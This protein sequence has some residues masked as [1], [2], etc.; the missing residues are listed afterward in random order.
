MN[1][2]DGPLALTLTLHVDNASHYYSTKSGHKV[3]F[4][5]NF[6]MFLSGAGALL[7]PLLAPTSALADDSPF[8]SVYLTEVLPEGGV[9]FE[10]WATWKWHKP[11]ER[12]YRFQGRTEIEYGVTN[13]FQIAGYLN[14]SRTKIV[15]RGPGAPDGPEDETH[16]DDVSAEF[17]YQVMDPYTRPFG[18]A[19]YFEPSIGD[20]VRALEF[21]GLFQKNFMEDRL[22][23]AANINLEYEW[24]YDN[25]AGA[26]EHGSAV[27]LYLGGSYRV[28]PGWFLGAEFLTEMGFDGHVLGG[29][30]HEETAFY[31]GPAVHYATQNWWATLAVLPQLPWAGNPTNTPGAISHGFLVGAEQMRVRFR[32]GVIL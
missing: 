10:Q 15:P 17:I 19:L 1:K 29:A 6:G 9:E 18:F 2:D 25:G 21:K 7:A 13:R 31:F 12:F 4:S 32:L 30:T 14:Y 28:A 20:G 27:E 23:F 26:W 5:S 24:E 3:R 11:Q 16:F 22:I 8:S